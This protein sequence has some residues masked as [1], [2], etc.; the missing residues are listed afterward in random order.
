MLPELNTECIRE[1]DV[2]LAFRLLLGREAESQG[3]IDSHLKLGSIE[4]LRRVI[5]RSTE[6]RG[7]LQ[8]M[9][10]SS[11]SK[12]VAVDVLDRYVQ[13]VD[14]HDLYVSSGCFNNTYEP[15]ETS[16]FISRLNSGDTVLDIGA[17]IGWFT[18]VAAKHTGKMGRIHSFEPRP[19]TAR[20]LKRTISDNHLRNQ[21][22]V[23]EYALSNSW[24]KVDLVWRKDTRNPGHSYVRG[25]STEA[26]GNYDSTSVTAAPLDELLPDIAPDVIKIDIEGAEPLAIEGAR[27]AILRKRP[28][29]LSELFPEQLERVCGMSA[30]QYIDQLARMGYSC[31][32]IERGVP[33]KKLDDFPPD[34]AT[35]LISVV[36]ECTG[37]GAWAMSIDAT[38]GGEKIEP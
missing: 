18:L 8:R 14:L 19:E 36:F 30:A 31:F 22:T 1:E 3:V 17:N 25:N 6:F 38:G 24:G 5:M 33:A 15:N 2:R 13:W 23:W 21:V 7:K 12:W 34:S 35:D 37:R 4:E 27:N 11:G 20:M 32:S 29:I 28:A 26:V 9:M 16:Y 10:F